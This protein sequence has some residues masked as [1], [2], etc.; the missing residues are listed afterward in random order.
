[1]EPLVSDQVICNTLKEKNVRLNHNTAGNSVHI[2]IR[3]YFNHIK[4]TIGV[5]AAAW[6]CSIIVLISELFRSESISQVYG[7]F[8]VI[9][10]QYLLN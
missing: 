6:P 8:S 2:S 5:L 1:M 9:S 3:H 10:L 7:N 4:Y